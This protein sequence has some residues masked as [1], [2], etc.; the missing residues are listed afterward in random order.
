MTST[1]LRPSCISLPF[2]S[3]LEEDV[4]QQQKEEQQGTSLQT[5]PDSNLFF[6]DKVQLPA[7]VLQQL[8]L[9]FVS[10]LLFSIVFL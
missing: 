8:R 9:L 2:C 10:A 4:A 3:Q 6:V 5:F 1:S 7:L